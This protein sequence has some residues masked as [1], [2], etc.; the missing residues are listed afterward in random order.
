MPENKNQHH[1]H[2]KTLLKWETLDFMPTPRGKL[3]Y[4]VAGIV[5]GGLILYA[6]LSGSLT[7]AIAFI[8]VSVLFLIVEKRKPREVEVEITDMGVRYNGRFYPYNHI[9]A[10]WIVYHPPYIRVLYLRLSNGRNF[11][12]V[13][14]ELNHQNPK[15]VRDLL[16]QELPE[17]EGAQELPTDLIARILRLQ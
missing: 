16:L 1:D 9:N 10:F 17:I 3:W 4:I 11:K 6:F 13:K 14:I 8:V 7:M 15:E 12:Y 2:R 5:M